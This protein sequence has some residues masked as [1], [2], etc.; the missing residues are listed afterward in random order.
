MLKLVPPGRR[1]GNTWYIARGTI[2]GR[3]I[4]VSTKTADKGAAERFKNEIERKLLEGRAPQAGEDLSFA[5]AAELYEAW[6]RPSKADEKR[7]GKLVAKIGPRRIRDLG[8]ADL[9]E[10]ANALYGERSAATKNREALRPAA[11]I[12]HYAAENGWC[13]WLRVKLFKERRPETRAVDVKVARLLIANTEGKKRLLL[14]WLFHQGTRI[15]DA[16]RLDVTHL[17]LGGRN[18][19]HRVGKTDEWRTAPIADEL[20][21]MLANDQDVAAGKGRLFPWLTKSGVYKW[22]Q[23][24]CQRLGVRFT[25]H[26]AR[27]SMATWMVG[28]G[29]DLRTVMEK[30]GWRDVKSVARYA[31]PDLERIRSA[32][33]QMPRIGARRG[34]KRGEA[35]SRR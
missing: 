7:I 28:E 20:V 32:S 6:R 12:L 24:L 35:P 9:V 34:K 3:R 14:A 23:P 19:R 22:L 11:A 13:A 1:K 30:G 29:I 4:E 21:V 27:H 10:A 17:D 26:M 33:R 2:G 8:Q 16:L 18:V 25:P 5:R 31:V 15:T